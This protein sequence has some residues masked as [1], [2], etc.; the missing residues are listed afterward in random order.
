MMN[1]PGLA[2]IVICASALLLSSAA[3]AAKKEK[4]VNE[5]PNATRAEPKVGMSEREQREL[6]KATDLVNDGKGAEALPIIDKALSSGKIGKYAEAYALQLKGRA[7]WDE[8]NEPEALAATLKAIELDSLPNAQHFGLIYQVAQMYVQGEKYTE[9]L[10]WLERW[11]KEAGKT[12]PDSLALKGNAQY[13]LERYQDAIATMKQ[14]IAASDAPSE[15]WNQILMASYFEL[16]Q[17]DEAAKLIQQQL[18]KSPNDIKLIKQLATIYV[19]G[20]KYPQAIE[21]LSKA[22]AQGLITSSDDYLQLAKLYANA[23]KPKDAVETLREGAAKG[24]VKP[25][26]EVHRLEG[27]L[28]S[29]YDD[30]ACAIAAYQKASPL[31]TDGN[32]DYQ[33]GY[34]LYYEDRGAEAK[35]ALGRAISKGGLRQEG[36]AYV[37]RGDVLSEAGDASGAMADWRKAATFPTAK[38]MAEQRIKAATTGVKLKRA[39][40]K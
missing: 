22:K 36:E 2:R 29:Q 24:I 11:E 34:L 32:I 8:D 27:D 33:L 4:E 19:N 1:F 7:Y 39:T 6:S 5:F 30:N 13:R 20:D 14:A 40:K 38:V 16:D 23:D 9:A 12:T 3:F 10:T 25:S 35:E 37:L 18:A 28:C 31:A 17:Y 26:L 21:V 15:S